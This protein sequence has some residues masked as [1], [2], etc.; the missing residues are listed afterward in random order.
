MNIPAIRHMK[1]FK[2]DIK[3]V[4]WLAMEPYPLDLIFLK[5][6][7]QEDWIAQ[8]KYIQEHL[9]DKDIDEAFTNLP[10]EVQDETIADIQRKLKSEKQ[11]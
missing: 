4:K 5:G 3:S 7:T 8:A 9:S 6:S 2:D 10:K 1:T 11:N